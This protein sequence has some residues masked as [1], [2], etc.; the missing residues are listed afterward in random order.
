MG[1]PRSF[2]TK[3]N[4]CG[5]GFKISNSD[6]EGNLE[7]L[8]TGLR[9]HEPLHSNETFS[10]DEWLIEVNIIWLA[11]DLDRAVSESLAG[12]PL[13][14]A[15][16]IFHR[17]ENTGITNTLHFIYHLKLCIKSSSIWQNLSHFIGCQL[18][19]YEDFRSKAKSMYSLGPLFIVVQPL[20]EELLA[21]DTLKFLHNTN[22][23]ENLS[24]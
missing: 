18:C 12:K 17:I 23:R 1:H 13:M 7:R 2:D 16:R 19:I 4:V 3:G 20:H 10:K 6:R 22:M 11:C 5:W 21:F 9:E 15:Y 24:S 8:N 14:H